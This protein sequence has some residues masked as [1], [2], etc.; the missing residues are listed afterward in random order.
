M[1]AS[2]AIC[3]ELDDRLRTHV[4]NLERRRALSVPL[5]LGPLHRLKAKRQAHRDRAHPIPH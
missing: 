5:D 2:C 4:R 3:D 1:T